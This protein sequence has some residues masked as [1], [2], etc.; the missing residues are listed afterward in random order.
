[1][2][3]T[4]S[5]F[6]VLFK[7]YREQGFKSTYLKNLVMS[8]GEDYSKICLIKKIPYIEGNTSKLIASVCFEEI[9]MNGS[10]FFSI[11]ISGLC[12]LCIADDLG[13]DPVMDIWNRN[14]HVKSKE[15][16]LG[17]YS[18]FNPVSEYSFED[19]SKG[20]KL[21]ISASS[22]REVV[23]MRAAP[24]Y[25]S[26]NFR[27][28][29]SA[30]YI[31]TLAHIYKKYISLNEKTENLIN[32][33]I[34]SILKNKKTL[35]IHFRGTDFLKNDKAHPIPVSVEDFIDFIDEAVESHK[36][37][38][39]FLASD[40]KR[41]IDGLTKRYSNVVYYKD[42]FRGEGTEGVH[43][44]KNKRENHQYKL[45]YEVLRDA[46]TL[47]S[48]DGLICGYS[49]VATGTRIIKESTGIKYEYFHLIDKGM[50]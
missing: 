3:V 21:V 50:N 4:L 39:I 5:F 44:T 17:F 18:F 47:A 38:Q 33:D 42:T 32:N 27:Y 2:S 35:G 36:F 28:V 40:D 20:Q 30:E 11:V 14:L 46:Y 19:L 22:S 12:G 6:F 15:E 24:D 43:L 49:Q 34:H 41:A 45:G 1:M 29:L 9:E 26:T 37:E 13:I 10:G 23:L 8:K 7:Q 31:Q 16:N 48:C 25:D